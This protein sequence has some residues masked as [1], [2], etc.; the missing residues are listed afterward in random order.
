MM[1]RQVLG[2]LAATML[3][4]PLLSGCGSED[5]ESNEEHL[6]RVTAVGFINGTDPH[7][8][9]TGPEQIL[10]GET[11]LGLVTVDASGQIVP[12]LAE[13]WWVGEDGLSYI[14]R[15]RPAQWADGKPLTPEDVVNSFRRMLARK[16]GHPLA[17]WLVR[18]RN[19]E[20]VR[21]GRMRPS[22]LGVRALT[23]TVVEI[24]L[25]EPRPAFLALLAEPSVAIVRQVRAQGKTTLMGLGPYR[26]ESQTDQHLTLVANQNTLAPAK[27]G[28]DR[29]DFTTT[30]DPMMGVQRFRN[31][32]ADVVTGGSIGG[33]AEAK[34]LPSPAIAR[35]EPVFGVY[36]YVAQ[37]R[38]GPLADVRLRRALAMTI[39]R[40]G[41]AKQMFGLPGMVPVESLVPQGFSSYG[42]PAT[43]G[44]AAWPLD[45]RLTEAR[46]LVAEAGYGPDKPLQISV[47]L[48]PAPEHQQI[49]SAI[50]AAWRELGVE[51]SAQIAQP[52]TYLE[53][54]AKGEFD[55]A[56]RPVLISIDQPQV[57]LAPYTCNSPDN[58]GGFCIPEAD[59][60]MLDAG[61][62]EMPAQRIGLMKEAEQ[63][64]V[65]EAPLIPLFTPVRWSLIRDGV[66]GWVDNPLGRHPLASLT[67]QPAK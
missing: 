65:E 16:T 30:T 14:F 51:V 44:W 33:L 19:G 47:L 6:L 67:P 8:A 61:K 4:A 40:H 5:T 50:A 42:D 56:L 59:Q 15:L 25:E 41:L 38:Q 29:I 31:N 55:L 52:R 35:F 1:R 54:A 9:S 49:L 2:F 60:L 63:L 17:E 43:P 23:D 46:R 3:A 27:P 21:Q 12:G 48:P 57:F 58:L 53:T 32:E 10:A 22:E 45:Q 34:T 37:T 13:S 18:I 62:A 7:Q 24:S 11:H 26:I 39:D 66:N 20:A 64:M 36:G 28:Y